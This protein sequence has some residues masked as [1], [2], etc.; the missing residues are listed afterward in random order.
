MIINKQKCNG[1]AFQILQHPSFLDCVS[2]YNSKVTR[3][4]V[5]LSMIAL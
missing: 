4:N 5:V 1:K 2:I 3:E